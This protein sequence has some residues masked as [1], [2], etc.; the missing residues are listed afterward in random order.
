[1]LRTGDEEMFM[2]TEE[3]RF[4]KLEEKALQR[5]RELLRQSLPKKR[6]ID[7]ELVTVQIQVWSVCGQ[8]VVKGV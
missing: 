8:G 6:A 1:M 4:L 3:I 5:R 7:Q 2:R